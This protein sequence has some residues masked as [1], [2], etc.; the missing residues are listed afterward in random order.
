MI[1]T[2]RVQAIDALQAVAAALRVFQE[3]ASAAIDELQLEVNRALDW[4]TN[5]VPEYWR[6]AERKA[7]DDIADARNQ[8][9]HARTF[10]KV[11]GHEPSCFEEKKLLQRAQQ[12]LQLVHEKLGGM[13]QWI[14][15]VERSALELHGKSHQLSGWLEVDLPRGLAALGQ[16]TTSL[17]AYV[18]L[19]APADDRPVASR[20]A[21]ADEMPAPPPE[22]APAAVVAPPAEEPK[23]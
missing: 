14:H 16:M 2:A 21:S 23:P 5:V 17:E 1:G 8:L 10:K 3:E 18:A 12:R 13:R 15:T 9:D 19:H 7:Y 22:A 20:A 4:I 6:M 11:A